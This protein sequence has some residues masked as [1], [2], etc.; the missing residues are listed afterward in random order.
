MDWTT[1]HGHVCTDDQ[2]TRNTETTTQSIM[3]SHSIAATAHSTL[4]LANSSLVLSKLSK[5][6]S[7][8]SSV[9]ELL[10]VDLCQ[11]SFSSRN[12]F[13]TLQYSC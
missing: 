3:K 10:T 11:T 13:P 4:T 9:V 8:S 5:R 7:L 1:D 12:A 6:Q 2:L